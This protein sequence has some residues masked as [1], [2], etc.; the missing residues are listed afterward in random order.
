MQKQKKI[1]ETVYILFADRYGLWMM[2]RWNFEND[3]S[4]GDTQKRIH[5]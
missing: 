1:L 2:H 5:R 4:T 3:A